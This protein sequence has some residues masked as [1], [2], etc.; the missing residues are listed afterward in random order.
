[1]QSLTEAGVHWLYINFYVNYV[2]FT[3][4]LRESSSDSCNLKI[5]LKKRV[6]LMFKLSDAIKSTLGLFINHRRTLYHIR[7]CVYLF[8]FIFTF[9]DWS[10]LLLGTYL[11]LIEYTSILTNHTHVCFMSD[12]NFMPHNLKLSYHDG[13]LVSVVEERTSLHQTLLCVS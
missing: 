9:L 7:P 3:H 5:S 6:F 13:K 12:F 10:L 8:Y 11:S 1:M 4:R 2:N